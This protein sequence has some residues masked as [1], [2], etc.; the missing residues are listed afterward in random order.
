MPAGF[1]FSETTG[2]ITRNSSINS[3]ATEPI[4]YQVTASISATVDGTTYGGSTGTSF[5]MEVFG[6]VALP[7]AT[8]LTSFKPV[9]YKITYQP[10][11]LTVNNALYIE[12]DPPHFL[13]GPEPDVLRR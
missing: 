11:N 2:V 12:V 6:S 4:T 13:D 9:D 5:I 8:D 10:S 3:V 1:R 7:A